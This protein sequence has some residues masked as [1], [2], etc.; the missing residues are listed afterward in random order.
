MSDTS[1]GNKLIIFATG[2]PGMGKSQLGNFLETRFNVAWIPISALLRNGSASLTTNE[3]ASK[4][5][6]ESLLLS[7]QSIYVDGFPRTQRQYN[8]CRN[9]RLQGHR[10]LCLCFDADS[11]VSMEK[12][13]N[14]KLCPECHKIV[15]QSSSICPYCQGDLLRRKDSDCRS[16]SLKM[17]QGIN[18]VELFSMCEDF[19]T[20]RR[21]VTQDFA[22][23]VIAE[24]ISRRFSISKRVLERQVDYTPLREKW[25]RYV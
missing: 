9:I 5:V 19:F 22:V 21:V 3:Q 6:F 12:L 20:S 11:K 15:Y 17:R 1:R 8:L 14:R 16:V 10:T 18:S 2:M 24:S 7:N 13:K 23:D 4:L 25:V